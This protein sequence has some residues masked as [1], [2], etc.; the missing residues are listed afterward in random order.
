MRE[1]FDEII[2]CSEAIIERFPTG[3]LPFF[4]GLCEIKTMSQVDGKVYFLELNK[5][6]LSKEFDFKTVIE[7]GGYI[8]KRCL[9]NFGVKKGDLILAVGIGNEGLTADSL[10]AKTIEKLKITKAGKSSAKEGNLRAFCPSVSAVTG[11]ESVEIIKA[12]TV[13]LQPKVVLCVDTLS[14]KDVARLSS[15]VQFKEG[16]LTP[17]AGIGN[18][19][20]TLNQDFLGVPVVGI[21][22]PLV[23]LAKN[24]LI[25]YLINNGNDKIDFKS[26]NGLIGDLVVT[27]KEVDAYVEK[28]SYIIAESINKA[29]HGKF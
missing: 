6:V 24:I 21:G 17:G 15:I 29:V 25:E 20:P 16:S 4:D 27:P 5:N 10:G 9:K 2:E 12:L 7:F 13:R 11:I 22:V 18:A 28:F 23:M 14:C 26:L 8:V 1:Y 3:K 19:K